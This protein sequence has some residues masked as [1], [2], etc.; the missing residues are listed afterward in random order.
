M[1]QNH[2]L[3]RLEIYQS[4]VCHCRVIGWV[5]LENCEVKSLIK[6]NF[7]LYLH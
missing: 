6:A 1:I 5:L 2:Q 3:I 4:L 7:R